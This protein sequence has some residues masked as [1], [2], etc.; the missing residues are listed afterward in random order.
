MLKIIERYYDFIRV[1]E[2][3]EHM[4]K[5]IANIRK[6]IDDGEGKAAFLEVL[7]KI[8]M[9]FRSNFAQT[10]QIIANICVNLIK[11]YD[12]Q[13]HYTE[14]SGKLGLVDVKDG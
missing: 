13:I 5:V 14:L 1:H 4:A 9:E 10:T 2:S 6:A 8:A 3:W 7:I 11:F 12:I